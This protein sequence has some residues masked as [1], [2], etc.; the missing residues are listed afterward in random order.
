MVNKLLEKEQCSNKVGDIVWEKERERTKNRILAV[1][2]LTT[3]TTNSEA[4]F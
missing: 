1:L 3:I 2:L 4:F